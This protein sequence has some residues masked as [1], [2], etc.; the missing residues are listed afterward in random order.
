M[1][2][3]YTLQRLHFQR[4]HVQLRDP[5]DAVA[6]NALAA[7]AS[8]LTSLCA[9]SSTLSATGWAAV[10]GVVGG[11]LVVGALYAMYRQYQRRTAAIF[12]A[13]SKAS[14]TIGSTLP[15]PGA[16]AVQIYQPYPAMPMQQMQPQQPPHQLQQFQQY[17]PQFQQFPAQFQQ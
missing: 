11:V 2:L 14:V 16:A 13:S 9:E 7:G 17:P 6:R 1:S 3:G 8:T 10:G 5:G 4:L 15:P 12:A